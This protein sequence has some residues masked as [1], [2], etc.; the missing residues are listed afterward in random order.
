MSNGRRKMKHGVAHGF[1]W[2]THNTKNPASLGICSFAVI[3]SSKIDSYWGCVCSA[4][5]GYPA[6]PFTRAGFLSYDQRKP[7]AV[8]TKRNC[9]NALPHTNNWYVK[10]LQ[11]T[12]QNHKSQSFLSNLKCCSECGLQYLDG[13]GEVIYIPKH[14]SNYPLFFSTERKKENAKNTWTTKYCFN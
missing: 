1:C 3:G 10:K 9:E 5:S 8:F 2:H 12:C 11:W 4:K 14:R 13:N 7:L 6:W